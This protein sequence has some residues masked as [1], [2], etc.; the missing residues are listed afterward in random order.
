MTLDDWASVSTIV[1]GLVVVVSVGFIMYQLRQTT[2]LAKAANVQSL[3]EQAAA[4]NSLLFE[5]PELAEL[6]YSYGR[7]IKSA[8]KADFLRHREMLVQWLIMH[9]NIYYQWKRDL[10]G[11]A[12]YDGWRQDLEATIRD[13]NVAVVDSDLERFFPGEFGK[14]LVEISKAVAG[15]SRPKVPYDERKARQHADPGLPLDA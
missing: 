10:L 2:R 7:D 15:Q 3:T 14:H 13:H 9:Q 6:W 11:S 12:I 8:D 1:Q 5:H 4:F